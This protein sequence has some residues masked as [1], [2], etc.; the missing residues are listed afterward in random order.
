MLTAAGSATLSTGV[1]AE[2]KAVEQAFGAGQ[3]AIRPSGIVG[4]GSSR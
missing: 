2:E 4:S 1:A 3:L